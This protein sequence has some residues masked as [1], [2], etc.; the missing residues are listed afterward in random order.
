[1]VLLAGFEEF[2][3]ALGA[4]VSYLN[5]W[6]ADFEEGASLTEYAVAFSIR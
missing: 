1:V 2:V 3:A 6:R 5:V 4:G